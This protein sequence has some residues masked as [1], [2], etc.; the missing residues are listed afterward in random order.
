MHLVFEN[1]CKMIMILLKTKFF[2]D[3]TL[4]FKEFKSFKMLRFKD[5]VLVLGLKMLYYNLKILN[6]KI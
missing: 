2:E 6:I 5:F 1:D 3:F 4:Q